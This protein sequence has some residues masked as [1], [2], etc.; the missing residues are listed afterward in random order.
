M[1]C[2]V[3]QYKPEIAVDLY[4]S[5]HFSVHGPLLFL[6]PLPRCD[7]FPGQTVEILQH[8]GCID[9][10]IILTVVDE[11]LDMSEHDDDIRCIAF[12]D[13]GLEAV[14]DLLAA[15]DIIDIAGY[16]QF[17]FVC[18]KEVSEGFVTVGILSEVVVVHAAEV[19]GFH[20]VVVGEEVEVVGALSRGGGYIGVL[21]FEEVD[22]ALS[23]EPGAGVS[24]FIADNA[25]GVEEGVKVVELVDRVNPAVPDG[26]TGQ[27][28]TSSIHP[29]CVH[30]DA[31]CEGRNVVSREG[32]PSDVERVGLQT[33]PFFVEVIHEV[34]EVFAGFVGAADLLFG[35]AVSVVGEPDIQGLIDEEHVSEVV[36]GVGEE[37][38]LA[39]DDP[40]G[41]VFGEGAE[42]RAA[43]GSSLQPDDE[44]YLGAVV[45]AGPDGAEKLIE[46]GGLSFGSVPIDL[47]ISCIL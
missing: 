42:L 39:V 3:E 35:C 5:S 25:G 15:R 37:F 33:R 34:Y 1:S 47:P 20:V 24:E 22:H 9:Y 19:F 31:A 28:H 29:S 27:L 40:D 18:L 8:T 30:D 17:A 44:R 38:G 16:T 14:I 12:A 6:G 21:A 13:I 41:S 10:E 2:A 36:P 23:L 32:L 43:S 11:H 45:D 7:I 26:H 4:P 46:H